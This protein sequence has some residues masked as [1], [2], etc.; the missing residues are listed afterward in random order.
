M[1]HRMQNVV[2]SRIN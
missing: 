1:S 2:K